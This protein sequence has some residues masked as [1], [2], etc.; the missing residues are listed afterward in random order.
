VAAAP[1]VVWSAD[2]ACVPTREGSL[3]LA[4][5]LD[6]CSR[7]I[8]GRAVAGHLRAELVVRAL[9]MAAWHRRPAPGAIRHSDRGCRYTS[10]AFGRR[11]QDAGVLPS[12]GSAGDRNDHAVTE[13]FFATLGCEPPDRHAF[14]THALARTA[15]FAFIE[16][17]F[18]TQR[19]LSAPGYRSPAE[20][21]RHVPDEAAV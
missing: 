8:V 14:C 17:L 5:V 12:V 18:N 19:R 7:R 1:D 4:V 2:I 16:G 15:L 3:Y 9:E 21:E 20:F 11:C 10:V 13:S 6:G